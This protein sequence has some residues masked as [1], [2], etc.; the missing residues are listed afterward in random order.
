M[1]VLRRTLEY[2]QQGGWIMVPLAV[3]SLVLWTLM[4]ERLSFLRSLRRGDITIDEV[5]T[6]LRSGAVCVEGNGLRARLV[7]NFLARRSGFPRLDVDILRQCAMR[8]RAGLSSFLAIIGVLVSVAP[9]LGL[10][11][12]VLGMIET[13][14]VISLFGTGNANAMAGGISVALITTEA[15]LLVAVPGLLLSGMLL[16]RSSRLATQ[17]EED[18]MI[19]SR[20]VRRSSCTLTD[21]LRSE[22]AC[23]DQR[24]GGLAIGEIAPAG[25]YIESEAL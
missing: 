11:G 4:L 21:R 5:I 7:R 1:E 2:L 9:L 3:A 23:I 8:E 20:I 17:L 10:L 12:T 14:Q 25:V 15:G 18:V 22:N 13:F 24:E 6:L 19:I 16:Q